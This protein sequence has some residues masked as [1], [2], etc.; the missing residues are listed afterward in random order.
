MNKQYVH[1]G[2]GLTAP[3]QW[4]NFDVSPTLRIQ[5]I[6][7]LGRLVRQRLNAQ[8][9]ENVRYGNIIKGLPV[10]E[11]SCDGVYCSHTLEH[12]SLVDFRKA[13]ANTKKILKPGGIFR[14]VVPDLESAARK[15][16]HS[17]NE[18]VPT[19]S[20]EFFANTR[21]GVKKRPRG[22]MELLTTF[23][24]NS[25]HLWMWDRQS[26]SEELKKAGFR[27]IR[28]CT[29]NDCTDEMF[30]LVEDMARFSNAVAV[31]CRK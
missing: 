20:L 27:E 30:R 4:E 15:Y 25:D 11:E 16:I 22:L 12:L 9:P 21:L 6:P 31:E 5:K 2:C 23:F 8:F 7:L 19:A 26:L 28:P 1:Y 14:C 3:A 18:S 13:L 10:L 17:L 29:F 24:G